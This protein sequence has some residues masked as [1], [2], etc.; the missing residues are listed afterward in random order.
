MDT[1]LQNERLPI[2]CLKNA[3]HPVIVG[4]VAI[5]VDNPV[6]RKTNNAVEEITDAEVEDEE[7]NWIL[8]YASKILIEVSFYPVPK[9]VEIDKGEN[10]DDI[11][12][13]ANNPDTSNDNE[14]QQPG[15]ADCLRLTAALSPVFH[16]PRACAVGVGYAGVRK[17]TSAGRIIT[18]HLTHS[19]LTNETIPSD[20]CFECTCSREVG[21]RHK[22]WVWFGS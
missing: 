13:R 19:F 21:S 9:A 8:C 11:A 14:V 18:F 6:G 4:E 2:K 3:A 17:K 1:I 10:S 7:E 5:I 20:R 16:K 15:V 12:N 22:I